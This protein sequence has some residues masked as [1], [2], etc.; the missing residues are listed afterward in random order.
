MFTHHASL[1]VSAASPFGYR[2]YPYFGYPTG[3]RG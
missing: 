2:G 1:P 3:G